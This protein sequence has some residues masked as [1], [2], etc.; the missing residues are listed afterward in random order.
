MY[1]T[2]SQ[3][4]HTI[5][6]NHGDDVVL[7]CFKDGKEIAS[8]TNADLVASAEH[9]EKNYFKHHADNS[10]IFM[11]CELETPFGLSAFLSCNSH[12]RKLFLPGT[13]NM[14]SMLKSIPRQASSFVV[15]DEDLFGL[16]VPP[17][18]E[19]EYQTICEGVTHALVAG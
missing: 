7:S 13:Y 15:V 11:S 16:E 2:P 19:S 9:K 4:T 8:L 5:P 18:A 10:P 12:G 1:T 17:A 6:E 3:S 14:S